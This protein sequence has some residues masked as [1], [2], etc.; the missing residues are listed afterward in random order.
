[1]KKSFEKELEDLLR[2]DPSEINARNRA[3]F[4]TL[5]GSRAKSIVLFGSRV[6]GLSAL[7][8]LRRLGIEPRAF[9]DNNASLWGKTVD[10]LGVFSPTEAVK[11]FGENSVFVVTICN[12][13]AARAQ[14]KSLNCPL[15]APYAFL[16]WKYAE[17]FFP[18]CSLDLPHEIYAQADAVRRCLSLWRDEPSQ[19]EYVAQLKWR[20]TL[21]FDV[22]PAPLPF[23]DMY[24]PEDLVAPL[25][26]E[27]FVDCG[28]FDGDSIRQFI[29][30]RGSSFGSIIALE[31]DPL[32]FRKLQHTIEALPSDIRDRIT[33]KQLA[34]GSAEGTIRFRSTGTVLGGTAEDPG[35]EV[36]CPC[37]RL[38]D[39]VKG[40]TPTYVKM[41]IEGAE[42]DA[43]AGA[44]RII[45]KGLAVWAVCIYHA[46]DHLW[47]VP[48]FIESL[49]GD[50]NLYLR[51]Y[52]E[53]WGEMI[54]YAVP[55]NRAK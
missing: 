8:G 18:Y 4:D 35:I 19:R 26:K 49:S 41:D 25:S 30:R 48:N 17:A 5:A 2:L 51:R 45:K 12:G 28:A 13:S 3:K 14:L 6:V 16:F 32:N 34:V 1:M 20:L 50:Y 42:L 44:E 29:D 22:L 53:E 43:L 10:G 15:V 47:K 33:A 39:I 23:K 11:R 31:A 37:S 9:T 21:D 52:A 36:V 55:K 40:Y 38:D 24:Y 7:H 46:Q 27:V 54:C